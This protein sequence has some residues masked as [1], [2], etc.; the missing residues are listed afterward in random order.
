MILVP[1]LL[2]TK[3]GHESYMRSTFYQTYSGDD[4]Q[5][6]LYGYS[7]NQTSSAYNDGANIMARP[8]SGEPYW[9]PNEDRNFLL[10]DPTS[11]NQFP[12]RWRLGGTKRYDHVKYPATHQYQVMHTTCFVLPKK[13]K[14][15]NQMN[16]NVWQKIGGAGYGLSTFCTNPRPSGN[17]AENSPSVMQIMGR[18]VNINEATNCTIQEVWNC[19]INTLESTTGG[20]N[21]YEGYGIFDEEAELR[22]IEYLKGNDVQ[23]YG[24]TIKGIKANGL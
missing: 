16:L 12:N 21:L 23:V 1:A 20:W 6:L 17:T 19:L 14:F 9:K 22:A 13:E 11:Q 4:D 15:P 5:K 8:Y 10:I 24:K 7:A 3:Q 2:D 18:I